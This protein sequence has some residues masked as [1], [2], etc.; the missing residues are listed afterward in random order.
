M[1]ATAIQNVVPREPQRRKGSG[2]AAAAVP[3]LERVWIAYGRISK[4]DPKGEGGATVK[5]EDQLAQCCAYIRQMDPEARIIQLQDN[6][7]AYDPTVVR[8]GFQEAMK[9][10]CE[11]RVAGIVGWHMDRLSRQVLQ[12]QQLWAACEQHMTQ[13]HTLRSG[14][15]TDPDWMTFE[16]IQAERYSRVLGARIYDHHHRAA[17]AGKS[18]GARRR[19]GYQVPM[20][21]GLNKR[22]AKAIRQCV[23]DLLAG[24]SLEEL[25]RRLNAKGITPPHSEKWSG[26]N[27]GKCLKGEH[28]AG[29]RIY[30]G[31]DVGQ[32]AW[33]PI[34]TK[35]QH[36][37]VK[38][39]LE[40][41]ERRTTT[42]SG[43]GVLHMLAGIATCGVCGAKVRTAGGGPKKKPAYGC[44]TGAHIR[45]AMADCEATVE[46]L[47]VARL[48][49]LDERGL[50]PNDEA[51]QEVTRLAGFIEARGKW[52]AKQWGLYQEDRLTIEEWN[53]CKAKAEADIKQ[54]TA[55]LHVAEQQLRAPEQALK[56]MTGKGA[57][58]AWAKLT[59]AGDIARK[60]AILQVLWESI[61]IQ[62]APHS[63]AKWDPERDVVLVPRLHS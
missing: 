27:L 60:R 18:H 40:D 54:A 4:A 46:E 42:Q 36:L 53:D 5:I 35:E 61:S 20:E 49:D 62:K 34:L 37:R 17:V 25:A 16:S 31:K 8:E 48:M 50:L 10:I 29:I 9:L 63:R 32:A 1:T 43:K 11:G 58:A 59:K 41:P 21:A 30:H 24:T 38:A 3:M 6:K 33:K 55:D 2:L 57:P 7:S 44:V 52:K 28:L 13:L 14:H 26:S 47:T 23:A 51:A 56:G 45:R 39:L 22:E 19:F 12:T 15:I